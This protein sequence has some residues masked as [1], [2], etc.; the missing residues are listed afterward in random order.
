[1]TLQQQKGVESSK[2]ENSTP[3]EEYIYIL[4]SLVRMGT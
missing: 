4:G 2:N 3:T 1:M